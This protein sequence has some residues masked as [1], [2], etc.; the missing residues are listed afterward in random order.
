MP[1]VFSSLLSNISQIFQ[2]TSKHKE[3]KRKTKLKSEDIRDPQDA[4]EFLRALADRIEAGDFSGTSQDVARA[5]DGSPRFECDID[6]KESVQKQEIKNS[7]KVK[8]EWVEALEEDSVQRLEDKDLLSMDEKYLDSLD[9]DD[10]LVVSRKMLHA[11]QRSHE[12]HGKPLEKPKKTD[13]AEIGSDQKPA[14]PGAET[15]QFASDVSE[16]DKRKAPEAS[17]GPS[18]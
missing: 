2:S 4:V 10:L 13:I 15:A 6:L 7:V 8:M 5:M 12:E 18:S 1:S 11:L 16:S 9:E 14:S 17:K 3:D